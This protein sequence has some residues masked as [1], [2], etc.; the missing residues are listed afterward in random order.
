MDR[1]LNGIGNHSHRQGLGFNQKKNVQKGK[2]NRVY[3]KRVVNEPRHTHLHDAIFCFDK[4]YTKKRCHYCNCVGH[5]SFDYYARYF[6]KQFVWKVKK[7]V[8]NTCGINSWLPI[9]ASSSAGAGS[10]SK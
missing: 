8:T 5:L 3:E 6:P 1:M 7:N 2:L 9:S 10:S 4:S